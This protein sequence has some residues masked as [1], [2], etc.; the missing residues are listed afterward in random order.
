[1]PQ[2]STHLLYVSA[3]YTQPISL[4]I[5]AGSRTMEISANSGERRA[6]RR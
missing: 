3:E 1:M 4:G 6:V 2:G 5:D